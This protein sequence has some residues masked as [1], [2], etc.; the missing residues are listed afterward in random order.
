M[1]EI[2]ILSLGITGFLAIMFV[3]YEFLRKQKKESETFARNHVED[4]MRIKARQYE[5]GYD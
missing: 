5:N 4:E 1:D 2:L 3:A